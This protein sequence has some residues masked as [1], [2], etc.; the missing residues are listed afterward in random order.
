MCSMNK[1]DRLNLLLHAREWKGLCNNIFTSL[2]SSGNSVRVYLSEGIYRLSY[3]MCTLQRRHNGRDSVSHHQP[4]G[5]LLN[6]LF[7]CRSKKT[8]KLCVTGLYAGNSPGTGEFPAQMASNEKKKFPLDD[9]IMFFTCIVSCEVVPHSSVKKL[10]LITC[11]DKWKLRKQSCWPITNTE[12][13]VLYIYIYIYIWRRRI[14]SNDFVC[15]CDPFFSGVMEQEC[16]GGGIFPNVS[17]RYRAFSLIVYRTRKRTSWQ[18]CL[19][20]CKSFVKKKTIASAFRKYLFAW[21]WCKSAA[22]GV[23]K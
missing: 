13:L 5:C 18:M 4:H 7:W 19:N 2:Q 23:Q 20:L 17:L 22:K 21:D 6:R 12:F 14:P 8:L 1:H 3:E 9:V 16:V 11:C 15:K 10:K